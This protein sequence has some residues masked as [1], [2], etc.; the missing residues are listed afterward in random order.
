M[1]AEKLSSISSATG[2]KYYQADKATDLINEFKTLTSEIVDLTSDSD[3]DGLSD[4]HETRLRLCNGTYIRTEP[5]MPDTDG[6]TLKDGDE[7]IPVFLTENAPHY[8]NGN[9]YFK[10]ISD[11]TKKDTDGDGLKDNKESYYYKSTNE[12]KEITL[13]E[14]FNI[15]SYD[16]SNVELLSNKNESW[17]LPS[18]YD[19]LRTTLGF[20]YTK[21]LKKD[22][23]ND[24]LTD[25]EELGEIVN[26]NG[27]DFYNITSNPMRKD[28]DYDG[29]DDYQEI[30]SFVEDTTEQIDSY[31]ISVWG[32]DDPLKYNFDPNAIESFG[33]KTITAS[34]PIDKLD[35]FTQIGNSDYYIYNQSPRE[36]VIW[37][38]SNNKYYVL[39]AKSGVNVRGGSIDETS[40]KVRGCHYDE[41]YIEADKKVEFISGTVFFYKKEA[42]N[43]VSSLVSMGYDSLKKT[44]GRLAE[45]F[46]YYDYSENNCY[47]H[48]AG[49]IN[50][51]K[52]LHWYERFWMN[53]EYD[54]FL[55]FN[56]NVINSGYQNVLTLGDIEEKADYHN[57]TYNRKYCSSDGLEGLYLKENYGDKKLSLFRGNTYFD[58]IYR[59]GTEDTSTIHAEFDHTGNCIKGNYDSC[60]MHGPTFNYCPPNSNI[61][62]TESTGH[63]YFDM[64]PY[65]WWGNCPQ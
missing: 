50:E 48:D 64:L 15:S 37:A 22:T 28:S 39:V 58:G 6:D 31:R 4:Y 23:D 13:L 55:P 1:S 29:V 34:V 52:T 65:F 12:E 59:N 51:W 35:K 49:N 19:R 26:I 16:K 33:N 25:E 21:A 30:R 40:G 8:V 7:V 62:S 2:G 63:Y 3:T 53:A 44:T 14:S 10:I 45:S 38:L 9:K 42:S 41:I 36:K 60:M 17:K 20:V 43:I 46:L 11:P 56:R 27:E 47:T 54:R 32:Y 57:P 24:G 18:G 5:D 61:L